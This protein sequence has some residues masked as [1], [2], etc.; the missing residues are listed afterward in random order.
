MRTINHWLTRDGSYQGFHDY[1]DGR[2]DYRLR[3]REAPLPAGKDAPIEMLWH[4]ALSEWDPYVV[5]LKIHESVAAPCHTQVRVALH[6]MRRPGYYFWKVLF[7]LYMLTLLSFSAFQFDLDGLSDRQGLVSTYVLA[8]FA[9]LY[10]VSGTL[11]KT[12]FLTKI[13]IVIVLTVLSLTLVGASMAVIAAVQAAYGDAVAATVNWIIPVGLL[14]F[15]VLMNT[16][17]FVPTIIQYVRTRRK[18]RNRAASNLPPTVEV[19]SK[20]VYVDPYQM[21]PLNRDNATTAELK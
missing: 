13:D 4:G 21:R 14:G 7:P 8:A 12:D 9:L 18:F 11:P 17:I 10:V 1:S 5:S 2:R 16:V 20:F 19:G 3:Y 6:A 15:M